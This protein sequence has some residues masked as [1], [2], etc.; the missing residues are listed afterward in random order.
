[1][2]LDIYQTVTDRI[3]ELME[4]GTVPWRR[5]IKGN[6]GDGF[7]KNLTSGKQYRG[8]NVFLLAAMSW[9]QGYESS[10][11]LTYKQAQQ[12][13]GQVKK[14][15][16]SSLVVFWKRLAVEDKKTNEKKIVPMIRHYRVFNADQ[17][18][19]ITPPDK[20]PPDENVLPFEPIAEAE[21]I[22]SGYHNPPEIEHGGSQA[23]YLP[24]E[25]KIK[26]A[27]AKDFYSPE[28]YYA[29]LFHEL[30]H[31]A[32]HTK[33]L[34][35]GIDE[36]LS[37]FGSADYSREELVA[38]LSGAFLSASA[39]ISPPTIEQSAAYINGWCKKLKD[40]KKLIVVAA[41]AAQRAADHILG[42]TFEAD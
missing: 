12:L 21:K 2:K 19:G 23:Y 33:R 39:G 34:N 1:M 41:G 27:E 3:S 16:K 28:C 7:P 22:V 15:E 29:T 40:D 30:S 31:S 5:P 20:L 42:V 6:G 4:Q 11:W 24:K 32:G 13:E 14:G 26:I 37:A 36:K 17:C 35:R 9:L 8:V 18:D 25:D 38:E 10:Y